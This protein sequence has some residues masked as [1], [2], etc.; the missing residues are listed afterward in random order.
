M[1]ESFSISIITHRDYRKSVDFGSVDYRN[2]LCNL[3]DNLVRII[4]TIFGISA[5]YVNL[6]YRY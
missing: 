1:L 6:W 3:K 2:P 4:R 5:Q